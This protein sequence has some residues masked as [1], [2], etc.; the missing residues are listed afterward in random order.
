MELKDL[1]INFLGDSITQGGFDTYYR[2][3][4]IISRETGAI[5]HNYGVSGTHIAKGKPDSF[6]DRAPFMD[7]DTDLIVIFGG[8]ND[9]NYGA[10]IGEMSDRDDS[11]FYGALHT[12]LSYVIERVTAAKVVMVT[13]LHRQV[14][15]VIGTECGNPEKAGVLLDYVNAIRDVAEYYSVP[16]LDLYKNSGITAA[17]P[18]I[19]QQLMPDGLHPNDEGH[20]IIAHKMIKFI[21]NL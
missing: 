16:V 5:C 6:C 4:N 2:F 7:Y 14:E 15:D 21:S 12:L 1:R 3:D 11:T 10:P 20:K 19:M 17:I 18:S 9:Y 13:P 8:T